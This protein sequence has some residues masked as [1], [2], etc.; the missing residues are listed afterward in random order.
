MHTADDLGYLLQQAAKQYRTRFAAELRAFDLTAQQAAVLIALAAT[1]QRS[2]APGAL[3]EAVGADAAT[4][5]GLLQRLERDGWL[6]SAA[7][8]DDRR[9]RLVSLTVRAE[10]TVP[11]L[12]ATARG[13]SAHASETLSAD[14]LDT[15]VSLLRRLTGHEPGTRQGSVS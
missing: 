11:A 5:T 1:P 10:Q 9:S 12:M 13:V 15:L 3:A 2:L 14:E 4:T 7:N 8:P 6:S